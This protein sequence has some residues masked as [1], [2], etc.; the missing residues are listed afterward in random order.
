MGKVFCYLK[1]WEWLNDY[2]NKRKTLSFAATP[3]LSPVYFNLDD[4][5]KDRKKCVGQ[6]GFVIFLLVVMNIS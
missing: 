6:G 5:T 1:N 3:G 4:F 2:D